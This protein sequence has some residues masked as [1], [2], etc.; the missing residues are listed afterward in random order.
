MAVK[1]QEKKASR[2]ETYL[3]KK[4]KEL[5]E[6]LHET[7]ELLGRHYVAQQAKRA[8]VYYIHLIFKK[9][10]ISRKCIN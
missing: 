3:E 2:R 6:E 8:K 4:V 5:E 7:K 9:S 10:M 1:A